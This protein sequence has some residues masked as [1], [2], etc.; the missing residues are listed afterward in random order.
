MRELLLIALTMID[1]NGA[2]VPLRAYG[3]GDM[4]YESC[5]LDAALIGETGLPVACLAPC[6]TEDSDHCFWDARQRGDGK[7]RS[8]IAIGESVYYVETF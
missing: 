4:G 1:G 6:A 5:A 8:F 2:A 3:G 7:G